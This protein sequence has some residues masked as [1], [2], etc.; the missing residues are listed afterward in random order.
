ML[1]CMWNKENFKFEH[2]VDT[3]EERW[4]LWN[5]ELVMRKIMFRDLRLHLIQEYLKS[6]LV[7]IFAGIRR[8]LLGVIQVFFPPVVSISF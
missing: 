3:F 1:G 5:N 2:V 7:H 6:N 8:D 4:M